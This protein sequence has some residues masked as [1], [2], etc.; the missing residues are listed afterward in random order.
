[1]DLIKTN[2]LCMIFAWKW[3]WKSLVLRA[4]RFNERGSQ[5]W[6]CDLLKT[7]GLLF[8]TNEVS[9]FAFIRT[10]I[11]QCLGSKLFRAT[12]LLH[13]TLDLSLQLYQASFS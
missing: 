1:M 10:Y 4:V 3:K 2:D 12:R 7:S 9:F 8:S 13:K 5:C 6:L 11:L